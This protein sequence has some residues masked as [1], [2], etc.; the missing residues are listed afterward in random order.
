[1]TSELDKLVSFIRALNNEP[2]AFI[3][4]HEPR[5]IGNEKQYLI[6]CIDSNFVSSVG[7]FV[8]RFEQMCAQYTG[9]KFAVATANGTSALHIALQLVGVQAGEEVITQSL[10]FIATANAISYTGAI[11][12]F[13]DVDRDTLGL[14]PASLASWL[15]ENAEVR[16][17]PSN[18]GET[19]VFN[20]LSGRRI[21]ACVP[22]HTFGHPAKP[23]ELKK[24]LDKYNIP[25]VEDS[26]ESIG[27]YYK[28]K[29]T[30]TIGKIGILS[31]NGNK[32]ITSGGGGMILTDDKEI[33]LAAKHLTTQAKIPHAWEYKHDHIGYN[34]RLINI[35]AA[36]GCAQMETLDHILQLKRELAE[37][38]YAYFAGSEY[39]FFAEPENCNSNYWLNTLITADRKSRNELLEYT[40][41]NGVMT[42]PVWE[43]INRLPMFTHC[44]TDGLENTNLLADRIVNIPS[45]AVLS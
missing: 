6:E 20:K 38:Y 16:E 44:P 4:L 36:L 39:E 1:M 30:G 14:S 10:T 23:G 45:S 8:E 3:P 18:N 31:F 9:A 34:Y 19:Q 35:A 26:A 7:E 15:E 40:N 2:E 41:D 27:S 28:G 33:A 13:I 32:V 5:F 22:M 12:V 42:R 37:K 17:S 29:H 21:S 25:M 43:P 24:I 11:P